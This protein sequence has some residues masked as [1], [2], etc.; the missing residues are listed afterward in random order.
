M[1]YVSITAIIK[2][3]GYRKL[4]ITPEML[5]ELTIAIQKNGSEIVQLPFSDIVIA[6]ILIVGKDIGE[7]VIFIS[8]DNVQ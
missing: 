8:D 4:Q 7:R 6:G 2:D 5:S 3:G 1:E